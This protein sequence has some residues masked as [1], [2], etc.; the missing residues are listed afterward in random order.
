MLCRWFAEPR[1]RKVIIVH[2]K[3]L[4]G[5]QRPGCKAKGKGQR[6]L[7]ARAWVL[8]CCWQASLSVVHR[9]LRVRGSCGEA[10]VF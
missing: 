4:A 3:R 1:R 6:A 8:A 9:W 10:R 2:A 5:S 7:G